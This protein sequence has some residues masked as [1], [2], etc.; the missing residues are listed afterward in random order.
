MASMPDDFTE[1]VLRHNRS[2]V[3]RGRLAQAS[4]TAIGA[5]PLCG[6][7]L[8]LDGRI[9]G[10]RLAALGYEIEA[11]AL[12]LTSTSLMVSLCADQPVATVGRLCQA[13]L[14]YFAGAGPAPCPELAAFESALAYRNRLKTL[15][16]PWATLARALA[17]QL[18]TS[19]DRQLTGDSA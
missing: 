14:D 1:M 7:S 16:L 15:T 12:T 17:G 19:T 5:N 8:V 6:D 10:D 11:S 18:Q 13:S 3:G 2:P 9:E 4:F